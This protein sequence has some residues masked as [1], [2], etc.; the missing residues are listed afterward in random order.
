MYQRSKEEI[1]VCN[2]ILYSI[3]SIFYGVWL[4][5][6]VYP[7]SERFVAHLGVNLSQ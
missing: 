7:G 6:R 1:K 2:S 3:Y 5:Y 4:M